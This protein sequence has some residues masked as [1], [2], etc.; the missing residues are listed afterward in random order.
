MDPVPPVVVPALKPKPNIFGWIIGGIVILGVGIGIGVILAKNIYPPL[1]VLP[2]P[3]PMTDP[4]ANWKTYS[5]DNANIFFKY[6]PEMSEMLVTEGGVSGPILGNANLVVSF[7]N[8][9]TV[10]SGTD[11]PFDGFSV[12]EIEVAKL[13]MPFDSYVNKEVD[14]VKIHPRGMSNAVAVKTSIGN[15][16]FTYI[17]SEITIRRY[18]ILSPDNKRVAIFS[19]VNS[20]AEFFNTFDQILSTFKFVGEND[21]TA[22][23]V[24]TTKRLIY[25][26]PDAWKTIKD[27]LNIFEVGYDPNIQDGSS[28]SDLAF[29]N[30]VVLTDKNLSNAPYYSPYSNSIFLWLLPYDGG[31]RHFFFENAILKEKLSLHNQ[32]SRER[33]YLVQ[34]KNCLVFY[35]LMDLSQGHTTI[36]M[37]PINNSQALVFSSFF[38]ETKIE[39][40]LQTLRFIN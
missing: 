1:Q 29:S 17:D 16:N 19:R 26:L 22:P 7:A 6:P 12:D 31:S 30:A 34:G 3:T 14:A 37:C 2:T 20:T 38:E 33:E 39:A 36:G 35:K 5:N 9:S 15:Q 32:G 8:K 13:G 24:S 11:A 28:N 27:N 23:P 4:T 10:H 18:F 21:A 40:M 25:Q